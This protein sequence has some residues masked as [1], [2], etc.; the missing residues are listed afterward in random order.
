MDHP[1]SCPTCEELWKDL[2]IKTLDRVQKTQ[3]QLEHA[4]GKTYTNFRFDDPG[5]RA[6]EAAENEARKAIEDHVKREPA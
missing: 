5:V 3:H 2:A 4:K 1:P 6:A